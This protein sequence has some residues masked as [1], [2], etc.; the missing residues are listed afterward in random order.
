VEEQQRQSATV[1]TTT[2]IEPVE[3]S[4]E[5]A[6]PEPTTHEEISFVISSPIRDVCKTS[7][8]ESCG[9]RLEDCSSGKQYYCMHNIELLVSTKMVR[10]N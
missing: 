6:A 5:E 9:M 8:V 7:E 2:E 10:D 3:A 1:S 4:V